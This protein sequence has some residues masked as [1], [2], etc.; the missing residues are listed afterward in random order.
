MTLA[1]RHHPSPLY[2]LSTVL[3]DTVL[4]DTVLTETENP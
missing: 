2:P 3:T 1:T 4:T